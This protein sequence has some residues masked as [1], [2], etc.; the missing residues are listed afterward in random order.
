[1]TT[2]YYAFIIQSHHFW[3]NCVWQYIQWKCTKVISLPK[4]GDKKYV[5]IKIE[6]LYLSKAVLCGFGFSVYIVDLILLIGKYPL[7]FVTLDH[8][9]HYN[10]SHNMDLAFKTNNDIIFKFEYLCHEL[11]RVT[12][13]CRISI[14]KI[15]GF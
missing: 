14:N 7:D 11:Y 13:C 12:F 10:I 9:H 5:R 15:L 8:N 1:M 4:Q 3:F 2:V 6:W